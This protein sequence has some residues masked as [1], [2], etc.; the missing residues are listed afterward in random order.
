MIKLG[1]GKDGRPYMS[2]SGNR[3]H[4]S[5]KEI[6]S[7]NQQTADVLCQKAVEERAKTKFPVGSKVKALKDFDHNGNI[8]TKGWIYTVSKKTNRIAGI[9]WVKLK[10]F[11]KLSWPVSLFKRV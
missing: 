9:N 2:L 8:I 7:I 6:E 1:I 5:F 3:I 10:E 11:P 4:L